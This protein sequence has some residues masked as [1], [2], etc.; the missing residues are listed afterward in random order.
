[1][2]LTELTAEEAYQA[3]MHDHALASTRAQKMID[4]RLAQPGEYASLYR[5]ELTRLWM[6]RIQNGQLPPL[7]EWKETA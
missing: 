6:E 5:E 1:M 2:A 4:R 7:E 3:G